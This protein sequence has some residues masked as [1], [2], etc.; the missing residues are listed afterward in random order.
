MHN[1]INYNCGLN[2]CPILWFNFFL[3]FSIIND[4]MFITEVLGKKIINGLILENK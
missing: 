3:L 4:F 1:R 2:F